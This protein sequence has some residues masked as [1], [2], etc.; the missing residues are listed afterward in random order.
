VVSRTAF[1]TFLIAASLSGCAPALRATTVDVEPG[2][3][4]AKTVDSDTLVC[5]L[6]AEGRH[7]PSSNEGAWGALGV[8]AFTV[9][10][11][12]NEVRAR[13]DRTKVD[14]EACMEARGYKV[15]RP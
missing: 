2:G 6:E 11:Y 14:A 10:E 1:A 13:R 12:N 3:R 9:G 5:W 4:D 15:R 8:W 7:P